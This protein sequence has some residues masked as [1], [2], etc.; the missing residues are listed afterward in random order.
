MAALSLAPTIPFSHDSDFSED[1]RLLGVCV[2]VWSHKYGNFLLTICPKFQT[3]FLCTVY[4]FKL[5]DMS[6]R[7]S[8]KSGH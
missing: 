3:I 8:M 7:S 2:C 4:S 5:L 1:T 6:D